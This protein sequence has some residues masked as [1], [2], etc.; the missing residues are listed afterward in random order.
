M[1]FPFHKVSSPL[2]NIF[3]DRVLRSFHSHSSQSLARSSTRVTRLLGHLKDYHCYLTSHSFASYPLSNSLNYDRLTPAYKSFVFNT[4]V[5]PEPTSYNEA[6]K[7]LDWC[8]AMDAKIKALEANS[9]WT[10][11]SLPPNKHAVGCRWVYKVKRKADGILSD[12]KLAL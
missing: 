5:I 9:T 1:I 12:I 8:A 3:S 4:F 11:T 10:V 6:V 2:D 7:S